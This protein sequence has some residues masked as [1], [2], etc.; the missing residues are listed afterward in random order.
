MRHSL[1]AAV[2]SPPVLVN[3]NDTLGTWSL[4]AS[5]ALSICPLSVSYL[6]CA[7]RINRA[8][9]PPAYG[10]LGGVVTAGCAAAGIVGKTGDVL[11]PAAE[12]GCVV[13]AD[14]AGFSSDCAG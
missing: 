10:S 6:I 9:V 3:P 1:E 8:D 4:T 7:S 11:G 2:S 5:N 13:G 14:G 12:P